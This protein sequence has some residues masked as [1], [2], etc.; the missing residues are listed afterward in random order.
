MKLFF[1]FTAMLCT[2]DLSA[3]TKEETAILNLSK[4]VFTW[5]VDNKIDSLENLF[6]EKFV[7]VSSNGESQFKK[8]YIA[9]LKSGNFTHNSIEVEENSASVVNNTALVVGKGKFNVTVSGK[10]LTLHLSYT[11]VFT[12][13]GAKK[14]WSLLAMHASVL[15]H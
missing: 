4:Q 11:E 2:A 8:Q 14:R 5:E 7:V 9:R 13:G 12:R 1:L 3:Q 10:T 15:E 6:D